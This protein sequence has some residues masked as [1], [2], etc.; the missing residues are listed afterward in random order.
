MNDRTNAD[1][2]F[3]AWFYGLSKFRKEQILTSGFEFS[4]LATTMILVSFLRSYIK[5]YINIRYLN[6]ALK[7][8]E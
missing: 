2:N 5:V 1:H 8:N 4:V 7:M 3:M 6:V